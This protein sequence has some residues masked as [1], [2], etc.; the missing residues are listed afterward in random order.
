MKKYGPRTPSRR[1]MTVVTYRG[2]IT[3]GE[4]H[5][6][7]TRGRKRHVGRN[8]VG[9]ITTRHKGGGHKRLYRDIDFFYDKKNI[10]AKV[11]TIE[12]DPNRTSFIALICYADGER[13]Y[14]LAPR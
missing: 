14:V 2:V 6:A 9:R 1:S 5:K 12:Y 10:P 8:A 11:E 7:L 13:R 3:R 4:P